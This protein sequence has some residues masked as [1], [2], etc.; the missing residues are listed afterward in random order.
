[1]TLGRRCV[2]RRKR[3]LQPFDGISIALFGSPPS[4]TTSV[5]EEQLQITADLQLLPTIVPNSVID[6]R[7]K[8]RNRRPT[9]RYRPSEHPQYWTIP[10]GIGINNINQTH[11]DIIQLLGFKPDIYY[12]L[13]D[14]IKMFFLTRKISET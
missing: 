2:V 1:M 5:V 10:D 14:K 4:M 9:R 7:N 11:L 12:G 8:D 3:L 6:S 13:I